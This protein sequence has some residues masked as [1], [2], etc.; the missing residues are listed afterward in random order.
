LLEQAPGGGLLP[1]RASAGVVADVT[2]AADVLDC[3]FCFVPLK[4][5]IFQV[6]IPPCLSLNV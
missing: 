5:P 2:A 1:K 3:S 6:F 4:P